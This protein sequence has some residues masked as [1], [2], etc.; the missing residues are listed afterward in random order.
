MKIVDCFIFYNELDML[1]F[2]LKELNDVVDY[3][4]LVESTLTFM[5]NP[6]E[7]YYEKNKLRF[8]KYK[9]KIIHIIVEDMIRDRNPWRNEY[10]QRNC[11][12]RGI[13]KLNL[14]SKD[15]IIIADCDEVPDSNTLM[16]YKNKGVE[17]I[18]N[19]EMDLYYYN[20]TCKHNNKWTGTKILSYEKYLKINSPQKIRSINGLNIKKGGWHLSYF[21]DV[22]FIKNKIKEFSHQEFN[23]PEYLNERIIKKKMDNY[24]DLFFRKGEKL[25]RIKLE[26]NEYLPNNV[27]L[28]NRYK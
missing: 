8:D 22:N 19:L 13:K 26:D 5:S 14:D 3:F 23:S 7:L 18:F 6:K 2:R 11:I 9:D 4:V 27:D 17:N 15:I 16:L 28:L 25:K 12:D 1:E 21:G 24:E 10:F 20:L